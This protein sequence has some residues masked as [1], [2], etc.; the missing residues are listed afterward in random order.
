MPPSKVLVPE[1]PTK[2][3]PTTL[4]A[5]LGEVVPMP[6]FPVPFNTIKEGDVEPESD[7]TKAGK[8][9]SPESLCSTDKV[10]QGEVVPKPAL[11]VATVKLPC[12][13]PPAKGRELETVMPSG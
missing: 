8:S 4:N 11:E 10:A 12:K 3:G 5:K 7:T 1:E 2:I 9:S 6:T 13:L